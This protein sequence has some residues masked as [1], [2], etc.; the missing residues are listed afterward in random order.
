MS[1]SIIGIILSII[2]IIGGIYLIIDG[3]V[4]IEDE[5]YICFGIFLV[6]SN[7]VIIIIHLKNLGCI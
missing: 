6:L 5:D 3:T 2:A 1:I 7:I 4:N